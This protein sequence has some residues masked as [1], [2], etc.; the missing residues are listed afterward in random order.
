DVADFQPVSPTD[1]EWKY[2]PLAK[3]TDL[4]GGVVDGAA[5]DYLAETS[6]GATV[7]W[8]GRD[9]ARIGTA[10]KPEDRASANAW[11]TFERALA[12]TIDGEESAATV[13]RSA[14]GSLPRGAHTLIHAT[15]GSRGIVVLSNAGSAR[16]T[17]NI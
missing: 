14:L 17:E 13:T 6:G 12:I 4:T 5:Y 7:T 3:V 9:D 16:L 15:A 10:G 1:I 2:T 11:S 8:V